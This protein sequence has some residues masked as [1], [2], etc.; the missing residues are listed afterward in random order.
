MHKFFASTARLAFMGSMKQCLLW[1]DMRIQN[2]QAK[3]VKIYKAR[4][5][6]KDALII[7]EVTIEGHFAVK[8]APP[9]NLFLT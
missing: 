8:D 5:E 4:P 3:I 2:K 6:S 1:A 9:V 7:G